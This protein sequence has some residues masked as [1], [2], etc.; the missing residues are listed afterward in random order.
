MTTASTLERMGL[1]L[2]VTPNGNLSLEGLKHLSDEQR[3]YALSVAKEHKPAI[4]REL[5]RRKKQTPGNRF[6]A[7]WYETCPDYWRGCSSCPGADLY[8]YD[9]DGKPVALN[10]KFCKRHDPPPWARRLQ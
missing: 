3:E 1:T 7:Y 10:S 8:H 4:L 2:N 6:E 9:E 5:R